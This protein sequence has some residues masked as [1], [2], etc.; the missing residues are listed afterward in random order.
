MNVV[1][2]KTIDPAVKEMMEKAK[3]DGIITA[4]DRAESGMDHGS[5]R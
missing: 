2:K 3:A 1:D 4:F 5:T